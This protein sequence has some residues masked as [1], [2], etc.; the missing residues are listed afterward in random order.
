MKEMLRVKP[1]RD[2]TKEE[3][4]D[5]LLANLAGQPSRACSNRSL[6]LSSFFPP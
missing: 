6:A 2:V 3:N 1:R 4:S 5:R